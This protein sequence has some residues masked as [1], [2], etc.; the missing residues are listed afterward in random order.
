VPWL[1]SDMMCDV[2]MLYHNSV[3][4]PDVVINNIFAS[5]YQSFLK[6]YQNIVGK[7]KHCGCLLDFKLR[8]VTDIACNMSRIESNRILM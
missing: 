8:E 5:L 6:T 7:E 3:L 4:T 2:L 1:P